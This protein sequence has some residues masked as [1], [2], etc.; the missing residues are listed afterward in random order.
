MSTEKKRTPTMKD[1]AKLAG[2]SQTTVSFVINDNAEAGIPD[3]TQQRVWDVIEQLGYRPN[4]MAQGLRRQR[5]NTIGFVT[6]EIATTPYAGQII[7]GAQ[8]AAWE[9][10]RILLVINTKGNPLMETRAIEMLMDR[11]VDGI[12]YATMYHRPVSPPKTLRE[13]PTVL[14]DCF[15]E[16]RSYPCVVPDECLGGYEA[17]QYLLKKGN[18]QVGFINNWHNIPA[19]VGRLQG[20]CEALA[21]YGISFDEAL[22][23]TG[24]NENESLQ[25]YDGAQ[26]LM[27]LPNPPTA[28]FCY[29]DRTA[30]GVYDALRKLSLSIPNDVAIVSFD[31][32]EII[33]AHLYPALTTMQLPHYAMGEWAVQH[34]IGL[35]EGNTDSNPVQHQIQCPLV[36]RASA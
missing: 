7:E 1:V 21:D 18:R 30:M 5:T 22:V 20:Y 29:N 2:V 27:Q 23:Y 28:I 24:P 16:D 6:D 34:L 14:L 32:Q 4:V 31:N 8:D 33:A 25:G 13:I 12:I 19:T 35:L 36:E 3:E 9:L 26:Y 11:K 15:A 17:T 10:E